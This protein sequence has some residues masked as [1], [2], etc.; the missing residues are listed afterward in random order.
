M[1]TTLEMDVL[2]TVREAASFLRIGEKTLYNWLACGKK[3][4]RVKIGRKTFLLRAEVINF[5]N[6]AIEDADKRED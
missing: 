1:E 3:F 2:W 6:N 5:R 4:R